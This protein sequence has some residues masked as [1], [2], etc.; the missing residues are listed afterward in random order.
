[1]WSTGK[2]DISPAG[3]AGSQWIILF[4]KPFEKM[5]ILYRVIDF[6]IQMLPDSKHES[7]AVTGNIERGYKTEEF[8]VQTMLNSALIKSGLIHFILS[9]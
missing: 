3:S 4:D 2:K 9:P 5:V 6:I 1:M 8:G 7:A